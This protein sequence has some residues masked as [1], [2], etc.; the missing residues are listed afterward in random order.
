MYCN[1]YVDFKLCV[2]I[3][4]D[5]NTL[6]NYILLDAFFIVVALVI[7]LASASYA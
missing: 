6:M 3:F 7:N 1:M 2:N 5:G 4:I